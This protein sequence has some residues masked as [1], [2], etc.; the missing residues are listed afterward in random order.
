METKSEQTIQES[1]KTI[2][3]NFAILDKI[4]YKPKRSEKEII[5]QLIEIQKLKEMITLSK[6]YLLDKL[7]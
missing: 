6:E 4:E 1:I 5:N 2:K 3:E 7:Y